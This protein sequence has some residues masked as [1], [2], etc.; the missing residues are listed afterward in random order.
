MS[1]VIHPYV[2][3][4][5]T[6][7]PVTTTTSTPRPYLVE[8]GSCD[9]SRSRTTLTHWGLVTQSWGYTGIYTRLRPRDHIGA[10]HCTPRPDGRIHLMS[11]HRRSGRIQ[12]RIYMLKVGYYVEQGDDCGCW[13][14]P[15]TLLCRGHRPHEREVKPGQR[16][17]KGS[18]P[19][20]VSIVGKHSRSYP[21]LRRKDPYFTQR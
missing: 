3:S 9:M 18:N 10:T 16:L 12:T 1:T 21:R 2:S 20:W 4:L 6:T 11:T 5:S 7:L 8:I 17:E 14:T 19:R 15:G 13:S